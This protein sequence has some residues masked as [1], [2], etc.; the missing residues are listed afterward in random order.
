M[1]ILDAFRVQFDIAPPT[2]FYITEPDV[3]Q[4]ARELL[5]ILPADMVLGSRGLCMQSMPDLVRQE[6]FTVL[7]VP[8]RMAQ[9]QVPT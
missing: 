4:V 2:S 9:L 7:G 8:I 3:L 5:A 1:G 6:R